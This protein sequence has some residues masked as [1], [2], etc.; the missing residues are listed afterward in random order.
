MSTITGMLWW[1]SEREAKV[2]REAIVCRQI[3]CSVVIEVMWHVFVIL[4]S[5]TVC[6]SY[7]RFDGER[8]VF[9]RYPDLY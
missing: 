1:M 5:I 7:A 6:Q 4:W 2:N 3:L 8:N 9:T